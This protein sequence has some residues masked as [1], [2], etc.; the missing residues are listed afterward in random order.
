MAAIS[1]PSRQQKAATDMLISLSLP[2]RQE[3]IDATL[4]PDIIELYISTK[5]NDSARPP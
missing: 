3:A 5:A 2:A 4:L 1:Y